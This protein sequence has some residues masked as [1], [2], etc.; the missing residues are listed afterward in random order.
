MR[1]TEESDNIWRYKSRGRK[2]MAHDAVL[3][4][5]QQLGTEMTRENYLQLAY[6][7]NPPVELTGEEEKRAQRALERRIRGQEK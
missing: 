2:P 3:D 1:G 6:C 4:Q 7:S 5:M